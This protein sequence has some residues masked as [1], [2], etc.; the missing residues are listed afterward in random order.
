MANIAGLNIST[1]GE[2]SHFLKVLIYG[3]PGAGK[4]V[5]AGSASEVEAMQP[6]LYV[7]VEGGTLSIAERY[8][9]LQR[10]R[11]KDDFDAS[12]RLKATA[13]DQLW[14]IYEALKRGEGGYATVVV[15][16]LSEAYQLAMR[17]TMNE[18][19]SENANLDEDVPDL[20]AY[21]KTG[22]QVR[23]W[24][25]HL[26][27]LDAHVIFTAHEMAQTNDAGATLS[28]TPSFPG[29]LPFELAGFMDMVLYLYTKTEKV[30]SPDG[31]KDSVYR[32]LQAQPAGK[33]LAKDRSGKL[34]LI[35]RDPTMPK[36]F[37]LYT[38]KE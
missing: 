10:V 25:R 12:G 22:S 31:K 14:A 2:T 4:T 1:V 9:K 18:R 35:L 19:V 38:G 27:D 7:D 20:R 23:R 8:P 17:D 37:D 16:N 15:D 6:V 36:I 21:G 33:Y 30:E 11:V 3:V 28:F 13:W 5:L 32:N 24:V 34:P 26:R 29:K